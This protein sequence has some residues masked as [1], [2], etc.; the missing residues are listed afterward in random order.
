MV[1]DGSGSFRLPAQCAGVASVRRAF[2][3]V[4]GRIL[5]HA[6]I[7]VFVLRSWEHADVSRPS[8]RL[9][10][11]GPPVSPVKEKALGTDGE[12]STSNPGAEVPG[13]APE[14]APNVSA[15]RADDA[16]MGNEVAQRDMGGAE[17]IGG[18]EIRE[19]RRRPVRSNV[20]RNGR[21]GANRACKFPVVV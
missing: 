17:S 14:G 4:Q 5:V 9:S 21:S 3:G 6:K 10:N 16:N 8:T 15:R 20:Q 18:D 12:L 11:P 1:F 2:T 19:P 7:D 13:V